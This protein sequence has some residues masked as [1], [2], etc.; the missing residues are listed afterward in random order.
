[1]LRR[2]EVFGYRHRFNMTELISVIFNFK[3]GDAAKPV[4]AAIIDDDGP[5]NIPTIKAHTKVSGGL[6]M[7][8]IIFPTNVLIHC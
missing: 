6:T 8:A 2:G 7:I 4:A 1:M 3:F 5:M